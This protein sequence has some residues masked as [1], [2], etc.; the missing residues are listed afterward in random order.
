MTV[1][2]V[3]YL[4]ITERHSKDATASR[5]SRDFYVSTK[6]QVSKVTVFTRLS[7]RDLA[8]GTPEFSASVTSMNKRVRLV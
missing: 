4:S 3:R 2:D 1:K 7:E 5:L 6:M 8:T